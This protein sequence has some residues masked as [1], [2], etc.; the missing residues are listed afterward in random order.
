MVHVTLLLSTM[1]ASIKK[2]RRLWLVIAFGILI[3]FAVLR[4]NF[5]NDYTSYYRSYIKTK[6]GSILFANEPMF[7]VLVK[8][9]PSFY[10][11]IAVTSVFTI[12]PIYFLIKNYVV[13][14]YR[15]IALFIY[16]G[17]PYLFLMSLSA[18]RQMLALTFFIVAIHFSKNHKIIPYLIFI[19][20]A[21]TCHI[22]A[23]ILVP[24][25]FIAND[26]KV[27][28]IQVITVV[29]ILLILLLEENIFDRV[30]QY[31]LNFFDNLNYNAYVLQE[32]NS[33]RAVLLSAVWF[34][35]LVVNINKLRGSTLM[36]TKLSLV[37]YIFAILAYYSGMFGRLKMYFEIFSIISIPMIMYQNKISFRGKNKALHIINKYALPMLIF[38]IYIL[39][40]YSFFTNPLWKPFW[41]YHTILSTI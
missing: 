17:N 41:E 27:N 32:G 13:D 22:S 28:K 8:I 18:I 10:V 12:L 36:F 30:L 3:V 7:L 6:A 2:N 26:R 25:Y 39:R 23:I 20:L 11:F 31:G 16:C 35:Y 21:T 1:I 19:F 34:V 40:Y 9:C 38:V 4:Y 29:S 33:L 5:G 24:F 37:G 14:S 15:W